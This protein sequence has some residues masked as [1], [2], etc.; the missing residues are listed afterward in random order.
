MIKISDAKLMNSVEIKQTTGRIEAD[1]KS[2][3]RT[4]EYELEQLQ[5]CRELNQEYKPNSLGIVQGQGLS[6]DINCSKLRALYESK[7]LFDG[8]E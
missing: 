6:I 3:V 1:M 7:E 5:K 2:L 8:L 4:L